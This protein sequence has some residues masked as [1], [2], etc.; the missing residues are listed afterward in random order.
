MC[1]T[2]V[3]AISDNN[4]T[5]RLAWGSGKVKICLETAK[6]WLRSSV[7][8]PKRFKGHGNGLK[9]VRGNRRDH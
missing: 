6:I 5:T 4:I 1:G 9:S 2:P 3:Q 8:T 7:E